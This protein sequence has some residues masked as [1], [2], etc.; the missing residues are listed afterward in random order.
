[1]TIR[2]IHKFMLAPDHT[3]RLPRGTPV[4]VGH[5]GS[6]TPTVWIDH[7]TDTQERDEYVFFGTG[8]TITGAWVHVGSCIC[9]PF[10]WHVYRRQV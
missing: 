10:V 9:G 7:N 5:Q 2:T 1:M 8:Q 3:H 6:G 4:L